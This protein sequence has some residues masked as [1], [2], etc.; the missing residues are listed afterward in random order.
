V[1]DTNMKSD[2]KQNK[3]I[4]FKK[5][6]RRTSVFGNCL[7]LLHVLSDLL[8]SLPDWSTGLRG[9]H[10]PL[11]HEAVPAVEHGLVGCNRAP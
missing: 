6:V 9:A 7:Y 10:T 2:S 8:A 1:K 4:T 3:C 5:S 11:L